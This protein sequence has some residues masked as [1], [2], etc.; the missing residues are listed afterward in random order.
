[1]REVKR[2]PSNVEK[3][4]AEAFSEVLSIFVGSTVLSAYILAN[5]F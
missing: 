5:A 4:L 1:M 3:Q 2:M